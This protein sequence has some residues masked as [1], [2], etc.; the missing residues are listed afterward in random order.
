ME[1]QN[2]RLAEVQTVIL[3]PAFREIKRLLRLSDIAAEFK[4]DVSDMSISFIGKSKNEC[5]YQVRVALMNPKDE[6][7]IFIN[8]RRGGVCETDFS[9]TPSSYLTSEGIFISFKRIF[10]N[11]I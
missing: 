1:G 7:F 6:P 11:E 5:H 2:L 4:S 10:Q 9:G 8:Y 3:M